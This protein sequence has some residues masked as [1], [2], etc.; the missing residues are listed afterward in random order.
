MLVQCPVRAELLGS[1]E[2]VATIREEPL[3]LQDQQG[4]LRASNELRTNHASFSK[5]TAVPG[6]SQVSFPTSP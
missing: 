3:K 2:V 5:T 1:L 4:S 6:S